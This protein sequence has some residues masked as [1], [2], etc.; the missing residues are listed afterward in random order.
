MRRGGLDPP[1][2]GLRESLIRLRTILSYFAPY[3]DRMALVVGAMLLSTLLGL[4]QPQL[5]RLVLD[6]ALPHRDLRLLSLL[7]LGTLA[8]PLAQGGIGFV[9][10]YISTWVSQQVS[11]DAR[12]RL[13]RHVQ[14]FSLRFFAGT[15]TG[16][17]LSRINRDA[18]Q[19]S[20]AISGTLLP[21]VSQV[22]TL[23][24]I[25]VAVMLMNWRLGLLALSLL[26]PFFFSARY[27]GGIMR[28]L[29]RQHG[30]AW[31]ELTAILQQGLAG[32]RLVQALQREEEEAKRYAAQGRETIRLAMRIQ[33]YAGRQSLINAF[34]SAL[35][36]A[37]VLWYG[38]AQVI[39]GSLTIGELLA[40]TNYIAR[41]FGPVSAFAHMNVELQ[42]ALAAFDRVQEYLE[43]QTEIRDRPGAIELPPLRG[44]IEFQDVS[45]AY[46]PERPILKHIS[47]TI[48]PGQLVALVGPTGAGKSTIVNLIP[49]FYDPDE[50]CVRIDGYDLRDVTLSSLRHQIATVDQETFLFNTTILE[51]IRYA[52]PEATFDEVV[53][54]AKA[55][56]LHDFIMSL[57]EGYET[58]V[59]ERGVKLSGGERQ[60]LAIARAIL[61]NPR[62]LI[63]DEAT[64]SLDSIA[65]SYIQRALEPLMRGR[66]VI[67]I[68]HRLSTILSADKI[69]V[70]QQGE[71]VESG[72]HRELLAR[73]GLYAQLYRTQFKEELLLAGTGGGQH[74]PATP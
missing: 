26:P 65:E 47:F 9:Q 24:G 32:I 69:L 18:G 10:G 28:R 46:N 30:E 73:G 66:T 14:T 13:Y 4:L 39:N 40:F 2:H 1:Q 54:A 23:S 20:Q 25:L 70:L 22:L 48:E 52:R 38:G 27:F 3:T 29:Y 16:D 74:S 56:Y 34:L 21:L 53:E 42:Q 7:V 37:L 33:A 43:L 36:P 60:R 17:I 64:S 68:A 49:R 71:L 72:T 45:F 50:G 57:P 61:R 58:V 59:G 62:I 67:A 8:L 31:S 12:D 63:L 19:I 11:F 5:M 51:N 35:G 15:K 55:A 6:V 44:R 41:L